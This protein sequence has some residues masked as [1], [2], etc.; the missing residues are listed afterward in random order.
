MAI[1]PGRRLGPYE[2]LSAIGAGGMGEV[3]RARDTRLDRIVAVKILPEHLTNRP[4]SR[5]RLEREARA[6]SALNHPHICTLYDIGCQDDT[7]Y[8]VMEYLAGETLEARLQNVNAPIAVDQALRF[9]VQICDALCHAHQHNVVHRD[10]KPSNI[11]LTS[12]GVKVLDFGV[13]KIVENREGG[14]NDT[15]SLTS[16]LTGEN[17]IVGTLQYMA[18]EQLEGKRVDARADIF[19][20]GAVLYE[21]LSGR[22]AFPGSTPASIIAAVLTSEPPLV[23]ALP[24]LARV[25]KKCLAKNSEER[26]QAASDVKDELQWIAEEAPVG[27]HESSP[28]KSTL[29]VLTSKHQPSSQPWNVPH[30]RNPAFTGREDMLERVRS[31]L[32]SNGTAALSQAQAISGLGG[33][34]KTQTAVE[35]A[36]RYRQDYTAVLW[37]VAETEQSLSSGFA[38]LARLLHLPQTDAPDQDQLR[39]AVQSWLEA[40]EGW[41]LV[42][43]N[44]DEPSLLRSYLPRQHRGH[45]LLTSRA[46]VFQAAGLLFTPIALEPLSSDEAREFLLRRTGRESTDAAEI[47]AAENLARELDYL[48]LALEQS[49]AYMVARGARFQDYLRS[50]RKRQLELLEQQQPMIGN[51]SQSVGTT[52]SLNFSEVKRSPASADLLCLSAFLAPD[53]IPLDLLAP[54]LAKLDGPLSTAVAGT[55]ETPV[56][57][58]ELLEPLM[59][60]SVVRRHPNLQ[61]YSIHRLTQAS[62]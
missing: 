14:C 4:D 16:S 10:L 42:F 33:I 52:W 61:A 5:T 28:Q 48:P 51:Y 2:I 43:D 34:G 37:L 60:Y 59:H 9:G 53:D 56:V 12:G 19:S 55:D 45:V 1:L 49:A 26:W 54:G 58:D 35:Y 24:T 13:A 40:N 39:Q 27:D 41:L 38:A 17:R 11:F 57:L 20:L 7:M 21:M 36:Y 32:T 30:E 22:K 15:V 3:Y 44:A 50:F 29:T 8:L 31:R 18:P 25:V 47:S 6:I 46:Q 23:P 62:P